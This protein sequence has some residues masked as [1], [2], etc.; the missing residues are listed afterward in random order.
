[1]EACK[2]MLKTK[3]LFAPTAENE[4]PINALQIYTRTTLI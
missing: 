4:C 2:I 1:M 3:G